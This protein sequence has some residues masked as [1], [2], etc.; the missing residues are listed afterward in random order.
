MIVVE[1]P[2]L[3]EPHAGCDRKS[4]AM[5]EALL[6]EIADYCRR[7][8]MA[9]STFG[10]L[11]VNDGKLVSRL[12]LGGRVTRQTRERVHA[13]MARAPLPQINGMPARL[14]MTARE[15][16]PG[17]GLNFRFYDNRQ[18]YLLF[19]TTCGEK[20][21]VAQRVGME[22]ANIRPRPPALRIFDAGTGD[23]TVLAR[24]MRAMHS[25]FPTMPFYIVGKE[26][27]LED[28]RLVLEKMPDR[29][30]EHPA[31]VLVM[32]NMYYTEA[33]WLTPG[34]VTAATS[35]VWHE[36]PL[37]G[38]TAHE[39]ET[40]ITE[41]QSVLAEHWR[42]RP[43]R[44]TGNPVYERPVVLVIYRE[45][46]KFLLD[47]VRPRRGLSEA[48]YDLVIASQPYR[49]RAPLEF[50]AQKVLAPLARSLAPGG[51]LIAIHSHG[52]DP[53][54]EIIR[55]VWP[56]ENPFTTDRHALLRATREA[57]GPAGRDLNFSAN[58]DARALF[59]YDMHTLPNEISE[60]IGTST[61]FAAWNAAVYVAQVEDQRLSEAIGSGAYLDATKEV[62][63]EHGG[64]WFWDESFVISRKR[65]L[66]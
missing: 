18:K 12:R 22:L 34:S 2:F 43:S 48:N 14:P 47:Q 1:P 38:A 16:A 13:F 55:R 63:R 64:L 33:P 21:A 40:Q 42:A 44:T 6:D 31:S 4:C 24:V 57:L 28:V 37:I 45:D 5:S 7:A 23:G 54:L 58:S 11:A 35:L 36:L 39:F 60:T 8:R 50:K 53:G 30:F 15:A 65:G 20:W 25:R 32:T 29:L 62:L 9:E 26:I 3:A 66:G 56:G 17:T 61:L 46:Y 41:L 27:S 52:G 10:R 19:V 51:R 49:A 59:R